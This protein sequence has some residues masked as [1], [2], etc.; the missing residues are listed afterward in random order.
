MAKP[1]SVFAWATSGPI[2]VPTAGKIAAG[3]APGERA[4]A[5]YINYL[6]QGAGQ[7]HTW[8]DSLFDASTNLTLPNNSNITLSG[9]G[10]LKRGSR[11]RHISAMAGRQIAGTAMTLDVTHDYWATTAANNVLRIPIHV[12]QGERITQVQCRVTDAGTDVITMKI[13]RS[14]LSGT[15]ASRTQLGS[16]A[17]SVGATGALETLSVTGLTEVVGTQFYQYFAEFTCTYSAGGNISGLYVTTDV[18]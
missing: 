11:V 10:A 7:W 4:A 5:Q 12:D 3:F 1:N 6:A 15:N 18:P 17:D 14:D 9:T 8:L 2:T 16:S 13:W